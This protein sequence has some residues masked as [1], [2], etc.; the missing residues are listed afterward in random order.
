MADTIHLRAITQ[1]GKSWERQVSYVN[2]PTEFGSFGILKNHA[3]M[4]CALAKGTVKYRFDSDAV[5]YL[6][7][8]DG[9]ANIADNEV[10]L[11]LSDLED[12]ET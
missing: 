2:L 7:I 3:P 8:S 1:N 4:L 10:T 11:L 9:I 5:G 6:R 12:A